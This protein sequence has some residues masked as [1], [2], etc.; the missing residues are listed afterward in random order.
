MVLI[1]LLLSNAPL[2]KEINQVTVV[3]GN[4]MKRKVSMVGS[5]VYLLYLD[6]NIKNQCQMFFDGLEAIE[7]FVTW[8]FYLVVRTTGL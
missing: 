4:Q 5:T 3:N 8:D 7:P 1:M 6:M 2:A